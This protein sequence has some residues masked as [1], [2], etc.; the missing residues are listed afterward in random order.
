M[1]L[2]DS[3]IN[4]IRACVDGADLRTPV[5][6]RLA[7]IADS[8]FTIESIEDFNLLVKEPTQVRL[9]EAFFN[10]T[11]ITGAPS[12]LTDYGDGSILLNE[13]GDKLILKGEGSQEITE[14][15]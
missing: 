9:V 11:L 10:T 15:T 12:Y 5:I 6:V 2:S 14:L 8:L 13:D 4:R 7:G 1:L 3:Q